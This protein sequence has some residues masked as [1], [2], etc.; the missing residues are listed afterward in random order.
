VFHASLKD[1]DIG[2]ISFS[3]YFVNYTKLLY[4]IR[5]RRAW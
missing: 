2:D 4:G 5:I 3:K 1:A